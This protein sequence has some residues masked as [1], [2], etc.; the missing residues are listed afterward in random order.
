MAREDGYDDTAPARRL[1][2]PVPGRGGGG[3]AG[4][5][6][7][8]AGGGI[9]QH[10]GSLRLRKIHPA[11]GAGGAGAPHRRPGGGEGG[12]GGGPPPEGGPQN[13]GAPGFTKKG[14]PKKQA[15]QSFDRRACMLHEA[16]VWRIIPEPRPSRLRRTRPSSSCGSQ[17]ART[18]GAA[19]RRSRRA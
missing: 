3:A 14:P 13:D 4:C 6:L 9:L 8:C 5:L 7:R 12:T 11:V 1:R 16:E 17:G 2:V 19:C 15:R 10:R 18:S